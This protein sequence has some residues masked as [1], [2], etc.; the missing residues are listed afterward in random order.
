M[1]LCPQLACEV[2]TEDSD[3]WF[4]AEF[5]ETITREG[6]EWHVFRNLEHRGWFHEEESDSWDA[7]SQLAPK[8]THCTWPAARVK[9]ARS[10]AKPAVSASAP[11]PQTPS[12]RTAKR[13]RREPERR[14]RGSGNTSSLTL[15]FRNPTPQKFN[16]GILDYPDDEIERDANRLVVRYTGQRTG[17]LDE[18]VLSAKCFFEREPRDGGYRFVGAITDVVEVARV[19]GLRCFELSIDLVSKVRDARGGSVPPGEAIKES[20]PEFRREGCHKLAVMHRFGSGSGPRVGNKFSGIVTFDAPAGSGAVKGPGRAQ[21]KAATAGAALTRE[22]TPQSDPGVPSAPSEE[23]LECQICFED[24]IGKLR[25]GH[26]CCEECLEKLFVSQ[27]HRETRSR[28]R[29][30]RCPMRCHARGELL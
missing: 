15:L 20:R 25:C 24:T 4:R 3:A 14:P 29:S 28:K 19:D 10:D 21:P 1:E 8:G 16:N 23:T 27:G 12:G 22:E 2:K 17:A 9:R 13:K 7:A 26:P 30:V 11:P 6:T 5:V 18:D